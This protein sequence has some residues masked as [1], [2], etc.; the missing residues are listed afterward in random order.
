MAQLPRQPRRWQRHLPHNVWERMLYD[1]YNAALIFEKA[2]FT[3]VCEGEEEE[4]PIL[5]LPLHKQR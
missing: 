5:P 3:V 2:V 4:S 1:A